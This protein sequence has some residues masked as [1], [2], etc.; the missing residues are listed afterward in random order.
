MKLVKSMKRK[1]SFF[2]VL[3]MITLMFFAS[4]VLIY[5]PGLLVLYFWWTNIIGP[6]GFIELLMIGMIPFIAGDIVKIIAASAIAKGITPK[7][8]FNGEVDVGKL[9]SW[10]MP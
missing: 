6:I 5:I 2:I 3:S 10:H 9:K 1:K 4:F 7:R 8:A